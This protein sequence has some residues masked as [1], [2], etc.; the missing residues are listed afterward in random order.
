MACVTLLP[1]PGYS[2]VVDGAGGRHGAAVCSEHRDVARA[3]APVLVL[4]EGLQQAVVA[5]WVITT[6]IY[7]LP[8]R[9]SKL[10]RQ[11]GPHRYLPAQQGH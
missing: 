8:D 3:H 9:L 4:V 10:V 5:Q 7:P 2:R 11:Q 1:T 6:L